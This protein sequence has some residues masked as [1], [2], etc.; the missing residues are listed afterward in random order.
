MTKNKKIK[1]YGVLALLFSF[2]TFGVLKNVNAAPQVSF[3]QSVPNPTEIELQNGINPNS[4]LSRI[5]SGIVHIM[6]LPVRFFR[7]LFRGETT[8]VV[9]V[10]EQNPEEEDRNEIN[11]VRNTNNNVNSSSDYSDQPI[12]EIIEEEKCDNE[13][14]DE[15]EEEEEDKTDVPLITGNFNIP[16][17]DGKVI[18][19]VAQKTAKCKNKGKNSDKVV[20]EEEEYDESSDESRPKDNGANNFR[21]TN[22][23]TGASNDSSSSYEYI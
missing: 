15:I 23:N 8:T 19:D 18:I 7:W 20:I 2:L 4:I 17:T 3:M 10:E 13:G 12:I 1:Y 6:S 9:E 21:I 11:R 16:P 5:W 22:Q 14:N